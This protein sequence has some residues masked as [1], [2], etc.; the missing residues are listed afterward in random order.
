VVVVA[1]QDASALPFA[2]ASRTL[3]EA[4]KPMHA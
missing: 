2:D 4:R 1:A 3:I